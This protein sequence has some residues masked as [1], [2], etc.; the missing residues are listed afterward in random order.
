MVT[1]GVSGVLLFTLPLKGHTIERSIFRYRSKNFI[2]KYSSV[3]S[4]IE[5]RGN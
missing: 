2:L 4:Y 5:N 3:I 1:E